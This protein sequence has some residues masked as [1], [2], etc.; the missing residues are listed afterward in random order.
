MVNVIEA[1]AHDLAHSAHTRREPRARR[2]DRQGMKISGAQRSEPG[3]GEL[4][5]TIVDDGGQ[6]A[7]ASLGIEGATT[8][9]PKL[10]KADDSH[11]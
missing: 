4:C 9:G 11:G 6:L 1:N 5:G 2:Y 3:S 10:T 8:L 7:H